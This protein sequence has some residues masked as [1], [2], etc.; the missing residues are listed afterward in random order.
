MR[1]KFMHVLVAISASL[2]IAGCASGYKKFYTPSPGATP[3]AIASTRASAAPQTP[4][5]ERSAFGNTD[6]LL[7]GYAKRGYLIIGESSF[8]SGESVSDDDAI[9]QGQ[10]VGAD[11]VLVFLPQYTGS[12][13][14]SVPITTP[15]TNTSYTSANATAYGPG[16]PVSAY[17]NATTTTYGSRTTYIPVTVNRSDY[18]AIYFVKG[19]FRIGAFVRNLN[20]L[21]RQQLETNQGVVITTI[22]DDSPAYRADVLTGDMIIA[23]DGERVSNQEAFTRMA[24]AKKGG[25]IN[26]S[27]IRQGRAIEKSL[28]MGN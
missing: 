23:M 24:S 7:A 2:S 9:E 18:G 13:T 17:G 3:E 8:N 25:T 27:L 22:V 11:L 1:K 16:G 26:L 28:Q 14:S 21:E 20:D 4:A 5:V 6:Q 12:V 15:T 10:A 19:R